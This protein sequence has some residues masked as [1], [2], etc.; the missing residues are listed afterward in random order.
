M[1]LTH[2][3]QVREISNTLRMRVNNAFC[4]CAALAD[5]IMT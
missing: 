5:V 1:T 4:V 3:L 2:N